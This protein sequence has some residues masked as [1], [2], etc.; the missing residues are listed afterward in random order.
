MRISM[1]LQKLGRPVAYYPSMVKILRD[2]KSCIFLAQLI[3]WRQRK[4]GE[5]YKTS[6]EIETET[7]LNYKEQLR[8]RK[9][10]VK[11][12]VVKERHARLEHRIY[13]DL[14][15]DALDLLVEKTWGE[16]GEKD[17]GA[18]V[19]AAEPEKKAE[20]G[21]GDVKVVGKT[22]VDNMDPRI[23]ELVEWYYALHNN[24]PP[25]AKNGKG[26]ARGRIAKAFQELLRV[27]D[28]ENGGG[29]GSVQRIKELYERYTN[30]KERLT[31][32]KYKWLFDCPKGIMDFQGKYIYIEHYN[33]AEKS[34][35]GRVLPGPRVKGKYANLKSF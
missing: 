23:K 24:I 31:P 3:Y 22:K 6:E 12:G 8:V 19:K 25:E 29:E 27:R 4:E 20:T 7:G 35:L 10:L 28:K 26:N 34:A 32:K 1:F 5:I 9:N 16:K 30:E 21:K 17:V 13:F 33:K 15:I 2:V 14:D 18:E 11:M